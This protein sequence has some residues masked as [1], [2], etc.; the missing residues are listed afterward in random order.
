MWLFL[1]YSIFAFIILFVASCKK[2]DNAGKIL[3]TVGQIVEQHADSALSLLD[4][5]S[6]SYNLNNREQ[7]RYWLLYIQAKDKLYE[8][9]ASDTVIFDVRDYYKK[10]N[11]IENIALSSFYCARVLHEQGRLEAAMEEYL[12]TD[13][14][15]GKTKNTNLKGLS[16]SLIGEILL[17]EMLPTDAI[18]YFK[19]AAQHFHEAQNVK[20][21]IISY[22][23][24]GNAYLM[25][26]FNDSAFYYYDKGL[27]LA[28]V[29]NDSLRVTNLTHNLGVAYWETGEYDIAYKYFRD[30]IKYT[31]NSNNKIK[32]YLNLSKTFYETGMLDSAQVYAEKSL[33]I[34]PN[35]DNV[36]IMAGRYKI[37]S[38]IAEKHSKFEQSLEYY[39]EYADNLTKIVDENKNKEILKL[40]QKYNN[41]RLQNENTQ[42]KIREY[43]MFVLFSAILLIICLLALF[44]YKKSANNK[45]IAL[46]KDN[47]ILEA[48]SKIYQLME[49]L[50]R[51]D[52]NANSFRNLLLHHFNILKKV[53]LLR[54]YLR[55]DDEQSHRLV[56][57]VNEIVYGQESLNWDMLY[58]DMNNIHNG[59]FNRLKERCPVL[60]ETEFRICCL[61]YADFSCSETGV[62]M[63]LSSNTVQMKRSSV[64]KK[65]GIEPHGNIKIHLETLFK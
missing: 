4:S 55:D 41:E 23:L 34:L 29:N 64:R 3:T 51:Y 63:G 7:N 15:A 61:T 1:R 45:K 33:P 56:R 39:K 50:N 9:I 18:G 59:L 27:R 42:L 52:S 20:N 65:L 21:E 19:I 32:L 12:K 8:N 26:S 49:I 54:Q 30:A 28:K 10:R 6:Y 5:I 24:I 14:L 17:K 2:V 37:L 60:D 62:I 53:T 13:E 36:F 22:K 58:H 44:F 47:Q 16:Q 11:D 25:N 31:N 48:Q 46:Q 40:T 43:K 57:K 35:S 38:Q